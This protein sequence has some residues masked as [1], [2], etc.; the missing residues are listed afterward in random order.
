MPKKTRQPRNVVFE[1]W[2]GKDG[3]FYCH[4][5]SGREILMASEGYRRMRSI[6]RLFDIITFRT[7]VNTIW[8]ERGARAIKS[9]R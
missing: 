1:Y 9:S 7:G 4:L 8:H 3:Q 2:K 5:R 6:H